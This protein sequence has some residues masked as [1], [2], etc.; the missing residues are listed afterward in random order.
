MARGMFNINDPDAGPVKVTIG[1]TSLP[2]DVDYGEIP[3][4]LLINTDIQREFFQD[5]IEI[6]RE[7]QEDSEGRL[8]RQTQ[9]AEWLRV[10]GEYAVGDATEEDL[11]AVDVSDLMDVSGFE[12]Y[13]YGIVP[14]PET[15]D[16]EEQDPNLS[17]LISKYGREA[18]EDAQAKLEELQKVLGQAVED[19][20]G[21]LEGIIQKT[22]SS[23]KSSPCGKFYPSGTPA[24]TA[25]PD[26]VR[27]CVTVGVGIPIPFPIPGPLGNI[28]KGATVGEIEEAIK[29]AG[30]EI[31]KVLSGETPIDEVF[32]KIV[33]TVVTKVQDIFKDANEVSIG[34]ILSLIHI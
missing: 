18:V 16:T 21:T 12:D 27:E 11:K 23:S 33:D 8:E 2:G 15:E 14:R 22:A 10:L 3:S 34:S 9:A 29:N 31:S 6:F 13:Y 20:F 28:F 24:G 5:F 26:W 4:D 7:S 32:D 19:P 25:L 1:E 30:Y 17:E